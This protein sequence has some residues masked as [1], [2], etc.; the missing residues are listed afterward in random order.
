MLYG[1]FQFVS[2]E[3]HVENNECGDKYG[4]IGEHQANLLFRRHSGVEVEINIDRKNEE[5]SCR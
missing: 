5:V 4:G 2:Y 1:R 3:Y